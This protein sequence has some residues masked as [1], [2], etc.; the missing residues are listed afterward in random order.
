[1]VD[2]NP[3]DARLAF[4]LGFARSGTT[5]LGQILS[6]SP[7]VVLLEEREMLSGTMGRFVQTPDG[8]GRLAATPPAGMA[9]HREA[10]WRKA[11]EAAEGD[12]AGRLL[13]DQTALN[14]IMLPVI[15]LLF[16]DA[17][18]LFAIRDPR[19]V[20]LSCFRRRFDPTPYTL[21]FHSL[22]STARVYDLTM[23]LA[24][25]CRERMARRL[26]DVRYE[27]VVADF[28]RT[29]GGLCRR[30]GIAWTDAM[31]DF[32]RASAASMLTT[33]SA[34]Q[35]RA[36]LT[37]DSVGAWR[38]YRDQMAPVL[39]LLAPWVERFGYAAE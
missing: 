16:H 31:R 14:T 18:V 22:E 10:Y 35:I 38:R 25:E 5:L 28:D 1:M 17:P 21:E 29:I 8:F 32:H 34:G 13:I 39:P 27:D 19:D 3:A 37:S 4:I 11:R 7:E 33:A 23:R 2:A 24:E 30:L 36:G 9:F 6:S 26:V 12:I 20:V 15:G